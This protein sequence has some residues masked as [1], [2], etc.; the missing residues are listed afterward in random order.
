MYK[1]IG[2]VT[3]ETV[4]QLRGM[5]GKLKWEKHVS[6]VT[7]HEA[8][9]CN[10]QAKKVDEIVACWP[11]DTWHQLLFLRLRPGGKLYRHHDSEGYGFHIPVE[12]NEDCVSLTYE[13]DIP[14]E[15]HLDLGKIYLVDRSIE[16]E[17]FNRGDTDRTHLI[18]IL[19]DSGNV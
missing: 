4:S 10:K 15:Q 18:V 14:E 13:N 3:D 5:L 17:S 6:K 9:P 12:T 16:H 7:L 11:V 8:A 1:E 19:K 2:Q